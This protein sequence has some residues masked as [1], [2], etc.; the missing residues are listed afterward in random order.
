MTRRLSLPVE[1]A[2]PRDIAQRI[3]QLLKG[4]INSTGRIT[5][6]PNVGSTEVERPY[7]SAESTVL[8]TPATA[9]AAAAI[10][11]TYVVPISGSFTINHSNS[12][13]ADREFFFAVLGG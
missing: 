11:T 12:A 4:R 10:S 3:N 5:L 1:G 13:E 9:N 6:T 2:L 8:L 7:V